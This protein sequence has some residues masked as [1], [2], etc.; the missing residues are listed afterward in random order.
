MP[1]AFYVSYVML[2]VFMVFIAVL[3][4]LIYRHFGIIEMGSYEGVQRDGLALGERGM[5]FSGVT[6]AGQDMTIEPAKG[7][8][9]FLLFAH[10]DCGPC[11]HIMPF[12]N[13]LGQAVADGA[14]DLELI[15]VVSGPKAEVERMVEKYNPTFLALAEDGSGVFDH[16]KVRVTPFAFVVGGDGRVLAKGLCNDAVRMRDMLDAAGLPKAAA[17]IEAAI[18][19]AD[20]V[21]QG[22]G[23]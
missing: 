13:H 6:A 17:E 18:E 16:Y 21:A 20:A 14:L 3:V 10:P 22:E 7:R 8:N 9:R 4:L 11:A 19:M 15:S 1:T 12:A 23:Q 2:W 5:E